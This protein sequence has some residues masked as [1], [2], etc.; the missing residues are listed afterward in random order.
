M[1]MP[2]EMVQAGMPNFNYVANMAKGN[3]VS[4]MKGLNTKPVLDLIAFL[5]ARPSKEMI[6]ADQAILK[7]KL[8]AMLPVFSSIQ[9]DGTFE[10]LK[11]DTGYGQF[12]FT[13]GGTNVGMNGA[14]KDGRFAEG[15]QI[16][17]LT[18]PASLPLPPWT[19]GM[20]PH[21][22][23]IGFDVTGFDL[24]APAR[25]FITEMDVTKPDPVPPVPKP[26][27]WQL[28]RQPTAS[29]SPYHPAKSPPTCTA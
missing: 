1:D 4:T 13:G 18:L 8:L 2:P 21:T 12:G 6:V 9:S 15:I 19:K 11:L 23:N 25:K 3:Y 14:V 10:D 28:L 27:T 29:N 24:D 5:V 22:F 26:P 16:N 17:G 20:I 7:E